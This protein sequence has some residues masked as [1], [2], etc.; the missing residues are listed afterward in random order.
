[1]ANY[2]KAVEESAQNSWCV[3]WVE[4]DANLQEWRAEQMIKATSEG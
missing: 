2:N 3:R 4:E 1:M